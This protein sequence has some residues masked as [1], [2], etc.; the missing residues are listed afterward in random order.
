MCIRDRFKVLPLEPSRGF[1]K[2]PK[3]NSHDLFFDIEGLDK[4]LNSEET[5]QDK[6]SLEYLFGVYDHNNKKEPYKY[7]WAH[8][9]DEDKEK[10]IELLKFLS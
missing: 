5:E 9:Q 6:Q 10:F 3:A 1:N 8:N 4:I 7:F 2:M